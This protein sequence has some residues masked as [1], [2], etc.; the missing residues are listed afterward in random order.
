MCPALGPAL[1]AA[2]GPATEPVAPTTW[3]CRRIAPE[4]LPWALIPHL[5]AIGMALAFVLERQ[6]AGT[7]QNQEGLVPALAEPYR[8]G[9]AGH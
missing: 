5:L 8:G 6:G 4:P 7:P 3:H 2:L 1:G 9:A